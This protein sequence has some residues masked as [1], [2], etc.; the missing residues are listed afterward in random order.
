MSDPIDPLAWI[1]R[2][3]EDLLM[4]RSALRR[5]VPLTRSACFH[6]WSLNPPETCMIHFMQR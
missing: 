3:E 1:E 5:K 2:A 4:V 6:A